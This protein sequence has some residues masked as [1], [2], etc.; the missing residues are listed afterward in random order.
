M[1]MV[2]CSAR[3]LE[4]SSSP[5]HGAIII[6]ARE[7]HSEMEVT[8]RYPKTGRE[9]RA[10]VVG[11]AGTYHDG[12]HYGVEILDA[13]MNFWGIRFP[14]AVQSANAVGRALL[15]CT[16]CHEQEVACF[17]GL[18]L[19]VFQANH[20]ISRPCK[21]SQTVT[22]WS[23]VSSEG[24]PGPDSADRPAERP[25]LGSSARFFLEGRGQSWKFQGCVRTAAYGDDF[26]L[27]ENPSREGVR[28]ISEHRYEEG[29]K[30][31][32]ALPYQPGGGNVFI[33]AEL[34]WTSGELEK[35][36]IL[37]GVSYLRRVRKGTRYTATVKVHMG[38]LG[39]G[40][41]LTGK[42]ADLSMSGALMRTSVHL[43]PGAHLR[44]G[45]EMG[46]DTFR[47]LA[48]VRRNVPGVGIAFKFAQ[49][50]QRNRRLLGRLI[51]S[52]RIKTLLTTK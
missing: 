25:K 22:V 36:V 33:P 24:T 27:T 7:L 45:I 19:G 37:Y 9:A 40:S 23:E 15:E 4:P 16:S 31:E 51:Q 28:F 1:P 11:R 38:V 20:R 41:G 6:L 5:S 46:V 47:P 34:Q 12:N 50:S 44:L 17:D 32:I 39:V 8:I 26:V 35:G 13:D 43:E 49:T 3:R 18:S 42:L 14:T 52:L 2:S 29:E 30:I 10:R 21:C 48:I